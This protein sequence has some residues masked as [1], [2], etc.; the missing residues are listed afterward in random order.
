M[1]NKILSLGLGKVG[2]L[3]ATLLSDQF[4]VTG[5]D[6]QAPHYDYELPFAIATGDVSDLVLM[7]KMIGQ[8]DAV[9]SALPFFLNS[10]IARIAHS[11]GKHYFDLTEDVP[12]TNEIR[13]LSE[14]ATA[15]MAPQCGLAPG[16]IGIIGAHLGNDFEKLRSIDMR[17]GALPKYPNGAMGYAFNWSAA[18]VVN[19]Y[20]NDAEAIHHGQRKM[21]PS[22]QGK[23]AI[24][25]NGALYEAFYTSGGL[26]TMCETY[27]GKLDRLDYK[28]IR[29]PGHC[30][31]MNFL[32][33]ELHMKEDKQR[34]EDILKNAKPPVDEDVVIIY[35]DAE[36]W[37]NN[38]LKR[39]EFCR[40]YGPIELNGNSWRAISWTTAASIVAVVEMV[41]NGSLPSKGF[42]KQEEISF[43]AL[44]N[45]KCGSLFK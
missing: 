31:L 28:T 43:E 41:A 7:E 21:V 23:E 6:K 13:K 9:V 20:I 40:S 39:N 16:L 38:E 45:T 2:T 44:L 30:D 24:Q 36:G 19:E 27:A 10:P 26:G 11:L 15:V 18:G 29:Y 42:I 37:K 14:T 33:N 3:V 5:M 12:T 4:E 17:V 25:I 32:I 1:I 35:A 22:L 8:F 34:L